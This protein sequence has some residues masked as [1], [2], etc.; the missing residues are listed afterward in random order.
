MLLFFSTVYQC[1]VLII[2][3]LIRVISIAVN[4]VQKDK[5]IILDCMGMNNFRCLIQIC[6]SK[7]GLVH[8]E[9]LHTSK[10][11]QLG[12]DFGCWDKRK[13]QTPENV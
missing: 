10:Y 5:T 3:N 11:C 4:Y 9:G 1:H 12:V 13:K 7:P 8:V 6:F 2:W